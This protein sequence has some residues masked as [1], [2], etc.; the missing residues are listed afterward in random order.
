MRAGRPPAFTYKRQILHAERI[1]VSRLAELHGTPQFIYS[2]SAI[3]RRLK[4][5]QKAF[6]P[7]PHSVCYSVKANPNVAILKLLWRH[8][9]GFDIVSGGELERVLHVDKRA[10]KQV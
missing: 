6:R 8:G 7:I 3:E 1:S 2:Q 4:S 10:A 9:S 5:F